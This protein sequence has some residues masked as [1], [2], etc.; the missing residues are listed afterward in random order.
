MTRGREAVLTE[1]LM[2]HTLIDEQARLETLAIT[3]GAARYRQIV[4]DA[5]QRGESAKLKPV[6]RLLAHW[7]EVVSALIADERKA[8]LSGEPGRFR[9]YITPVLR[10]I[11][12]DAAAVILMQEAVNACIRDPGGVKTAGLAYN[13]GRGVLAEIEAGLLKK[14][15]PDSYREIFSSPKSMTD[16]RVR[17]AWSKIKGK[18]ATKK[19]ICVHAGSVLL[20]ILIRGAS[21]TDYFEEEFSPCF[22]EFLVSRWKGKKSIDISYTRMTDHAFQIIDDG[23]ANRRLLRPRYLPMVVRPYQWSEDAQG[24]YIKIRTPLISKPS[25]EQKRA[26]DAA[27]KTLIYRALDVI[28][29]AAMRV[30]R[31]VEAVQREVWASGGGEL[32]IPSGSGLEMDRPFPEGGSDEEIKAWK[33]D[34]V[35]MHRENIRRRCD[36]EDYLRLRW[37]TEMFLDRDPIYLPNMLDFRGRMFP[38]PTHLTYHGDDVPRALLQFSDPKDASDPDSRYWIMVHAANCFGFDKVSFDEQAEWVES[39]AAEIARTVAEPLSFEWWKLADKPW[40]FLQACY[41]LA[42][43]EEAARLPVQR[44]GTVNGMQHYVALSRDAGGAPFVNLEPGDRPGDLYSAVLAVAER[45]VSADAEAGNAE[46]KLVLPLLSRKVVKQNV[47]TVVY[48]VTAHGAAAQIRERLKEAGLTGKPLFQSSVY[49]SRVVLG[50]I[51]DLCS[52]ASAAMDWLTECAKLI[53]SE[54]LAVEWVSPAGMPVI[55]PYYRSSSLNIQTKMRSMTYRVRRPDDPVWIKK[56]VDGVA[57]NF[58]HS[59][60]ASHLMMTAASCGDAGITLTTIHDA[61]RTHAASVGELDCIIREQFVTLHA[62]PLLPKLAQQWSDRYHGIEFPEPPAVGA[63]D[64]SRVLDSAYFF[65]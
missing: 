22:E 41:A 49:L 23:H 12:P 61:Y 59:I 44:D 3:D 64:I 45:T 25:K 13:I 65:S 20:D 60:D 29:G 2:G 63:F 26:L 16:R 35:K 38:I 19:R 11:S 10:E 42:Y 5:V 1:P 9:A 37:I 30:D 46:A 8:C 24:G 51:G 54:N 28:G 40:Q 53:A 32:G 27:D 6:E 21:A 36:R 4:E 62:D 7:F 58:I 56:Q 52:S 39:H 31:R 14:E 57:P 50:S 18:V 17:L 43:P 34:A 15:D 47:M 48:G 55:Q 33:V